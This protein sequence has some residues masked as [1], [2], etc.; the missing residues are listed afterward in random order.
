MKYREMGDGP[1]GF[2]SWIEQVR[3][4][5]R[6]WTLRSWLLDHGAPLWIYANNGERARA[7][8]RRLWLSQVTATVGGFSLGLNFRRFHDRVWDNGS[9]IDIWIELLWISIRIVWLRQ[10]KGVDY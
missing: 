9:G 6:F 7:A 1:R 3:R 10:V 4:D 2:R 5:N 8:G